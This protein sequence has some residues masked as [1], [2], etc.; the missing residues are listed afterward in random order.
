MATLK[1]LPQQAPNTNAITASAQPGTS[2]TSKFTRPLAYYSAP[3]ERGFA[4]GLQ[5]A[6]RVLATL[7]AQRCHSKMSPPRQG[8]YPC[9]GDSAQ[10]DRPTRYLEASVT[11]S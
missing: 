4:A 1:K 3:A 11:S 9:A 2:E 5:P 6:C 8:V 10:G 7:R